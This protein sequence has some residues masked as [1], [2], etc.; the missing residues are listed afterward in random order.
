MPKILLRTVTFVVSAGVVAAC[1]SKG[2][3]PGPATLTYPVTETVEQ[4][5]LYHGTPVADPYRW[6]EEDVRESERVAEWVTAQNDVTFA[7]LEDI[8]ERAAIRERMTALW[9]FEKFSVP[10]KH[11][12]R[13]FYEYNDGLANQDQIY[14]QRSVDGEPELLIDPN[15]WSEDG[16]VALSAY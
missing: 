1:A 8:P 7:Y 11:G 16:T 2:P 6:L 14:L 15:L 12:G 5:D 9:D 3:E 4:I 13:Y 10:V